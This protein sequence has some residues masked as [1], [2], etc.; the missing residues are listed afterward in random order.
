[1]DRITQDIVK[2]K[3]NDGNGGN[4]FLFWQLFERLDHI[5]NELESV[6]DNLRCEIERMKP[7]QQT[8]LVAV[9]KKLVN[10]YKIPPIKILRHKDL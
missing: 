5:A 8:L 7:Y 6:R 2:E 3:L 4:A 10:K 1:M 9:V